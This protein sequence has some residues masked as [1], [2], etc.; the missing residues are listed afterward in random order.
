M[1]IACILHILIRKELVESLLRT[2]F[3][4]S[5]IGVATTMLFKRCELHN[6]NCSYMELAWSSDE[7]IP[8]QMDKIY[9]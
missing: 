3:F 7:C 1:W 4:G 6:A 5:S 2:P 9:G 8:V